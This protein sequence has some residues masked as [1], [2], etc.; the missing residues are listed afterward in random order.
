[1][2]TCDCNDKQISILQ[3]PIS[4]AADGTCYTNTFYCFFLE[5]IGLDISCES[6]VRHRI[7]MKDQL[8]FSSKDKNKK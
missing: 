8:L 3:A 2:A 5:K 4:T 1:M 6:S 7:H